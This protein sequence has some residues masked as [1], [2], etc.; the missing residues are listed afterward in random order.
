MIWAQAT[1]PEV[2]L[3]QL[4]LSGGSLG[5]TLVLGWYFS[6]KL[7]AGQAKCAAERELTNNAFLKRLEEKDK[8]FVAAFEKKDVEQKE[9]LRSLSDTC[10]EVHRESSSA[11]RECNRTLARATYVQEVAISRLK[12]SPVQAVGPTDSQIVRD[13][14]RFEE[15]T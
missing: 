5:V 1:P 4:A 10:H 15:Q 6:G 9:F 3:L 8:L 7:E 2:S 11:V 14:N 13:N 12:I